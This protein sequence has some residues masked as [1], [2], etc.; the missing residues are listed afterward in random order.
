MSA[1]RIKINMD[2]QDCNKCPID[3]L[4]DN[5]HDCVYKVY[6]A[7]VKAGKKQMKDAYKKRLPSLYCQL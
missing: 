4:C 2:R 7:G 3:K 6:L 5:Y 1:K